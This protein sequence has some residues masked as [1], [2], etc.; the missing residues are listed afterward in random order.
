MS[1]QP[2]KI[3]ATRTRFGSG[4]VCLE[5][6][7]AS[8]HLECLAWLSAGQFKRATGFLLQKGQTARLVLG[9]VPHV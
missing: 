2:E 3:L 9:R 8:G 1:K 7:D 5:I 4:T 6:E